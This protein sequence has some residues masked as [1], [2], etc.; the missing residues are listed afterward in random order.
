MVLSVSVP[1]EKTVSLVL[2]V[3]VLSQ[4]HVSVGISSHK[5]DSLDI[6]QIVA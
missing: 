2:D 4:K 1:M 6:A 3:I 5:A